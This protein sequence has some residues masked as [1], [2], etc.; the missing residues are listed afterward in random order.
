MVARKILPPPFHPPQAGERK[1]ALTRRGVLRVALLAAT[2]GTALRQA[3]AQQ[4]MSKAEAEYQDR[5]KN[6]LACAACT[7]FR[8]PRSCQVVQGDISP[9]GWCKFF[10]LPD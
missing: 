1:V 7:L 2:V 3:L 4:K 6:G 8:P 5:P 10:D 9:S